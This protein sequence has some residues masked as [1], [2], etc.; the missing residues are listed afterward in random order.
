[1]ATVGN[2]V[3]EK[4]VRREERTAQEWFELAMERGLSGA[5]GKRNK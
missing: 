1:M 3:S 5:F 4:C 2:G